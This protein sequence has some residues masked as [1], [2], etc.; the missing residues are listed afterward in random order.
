MQDLV[1]LENDQR[2]GK[3]DASR[4]RARR[5]ELIAALEHVYGALDT[6]EAGPPPSRA[7]VAA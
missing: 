6:D 5:E 2:K 7:G 1:R 3:I 4:Y